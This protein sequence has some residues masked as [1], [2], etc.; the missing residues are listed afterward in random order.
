MFIHAYIHNTQHTTHNN[1][2]IIKQQSMEIP[3][4]DLLWF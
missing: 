3:Y 4:N 1:I 2:I